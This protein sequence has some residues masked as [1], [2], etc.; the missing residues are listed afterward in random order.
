MS[1][2]TA[3][4]SEVSGMAAS[5]KLVGLCR[6]NVPLAAWKCRIGAWPPLWKRIRWVAASSS[7]MKAVMKRS[8]ASV[9]GQLVVDLHECGLEVGAHPESH[10]QHRLHLRHR[11]RRRDAMAGRIAQD[12]EQALVDARDRSNVSPPVRL[13]RPERAV[14]VVAGKRGHVGGQR[15]H[16]DDARHFQ[17]LAHLLALDHRLGHAH[18]LQRDRALRGQRRGEHLVV[19]VEDAVPPC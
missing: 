9:V 18:P 19:V 6:A 4:R 7:P 3:G 8:S 14:D 12:D 17:L 16:L 1:R 10:A 5:G 15:A 13:G 2:L 11:K